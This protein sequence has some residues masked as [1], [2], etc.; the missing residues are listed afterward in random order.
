VQTIDTPS[1]SSP[2]SIP[3]VFDFIWVYIAKVR[4][5]EEELGR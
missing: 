5:V 1:Q 3:A 4:S 2:T